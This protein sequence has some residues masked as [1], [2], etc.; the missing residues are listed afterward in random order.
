MKHIFK[1]DFQVDIAI[2]KSYIKKTEPSAKQ[3]QSFIEARLWSKGQDIKEIEV[4]HEDGH[5]Y[6]VNIY[7]T[8]RHYVSLYFPWRNDE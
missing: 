1:K 5:F 8:N 6:V 2:I 3:L 4:E 7:G